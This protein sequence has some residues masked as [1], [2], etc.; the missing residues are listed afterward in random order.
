LKRTPPA[1]PALG[2]LTPLIALDVVVLDTETT[3][4]D[5]RKD[6]IVQIGAVRMVGR[7]ILANETFDVIV[8]PQMPIPEVAQRIHGLKDADVAGSRTIADV[9]PELAAFIGGA[10]VVGHSIH[11]D[12]AILRH[13]AERTGVA[14]TEPK[15]LDVALMVAGLDPA[16]VD[17]SLDNLALNLGVDI[18]GRHTALGDARATADVY[19]GLQPRLIAKGIRTLAEAEHLCRKPAGLIA[20][21]EEA[22]W[23]ERPKDKRDFAHAVLR[24]G[25][26]KAIDSYLYRNRLGDVMSSPPISL[27]QTAP[28][29]K[30]ARLMTDRGIGCLI[31][32][33]DGLD[34]GILTE[35]D[36]LHALAA[37]GSDAPELSV[38]TLM[39]APVISAPADTFLYRAL[40]LMARRNLRYLGVTDGGGRVTGV[41]TLR[42]LLRERALATLT[43][44]DEIAAATRPRDLAKVQS[45][46][47]ALASGLLDDGQ[48][49]RNVCA[50]IAAEGKAMTARAAELAEAELVAAGAGPAPADYALLVLGSG[51][52][53]ESML[54]ADQDNALVIDDSYTGDLDSPDDWFTRFAAR[55]NEILDR[56]GIPLCSGGVMARNRPWRRRLGEWEGQLAEWAAHPSP[57]ALLNVDIFYDFTP[58]QVSGSAGARLAEAL[59]IHAMETARASLTM[60]RAL[61]ETAASHGP[62]LGLFGRIRKDDQGRVD[63]K[64]GGLLPIVAGARTIALRQGISDLT[65]PGRLLAAAKAAHRSE[66]DAEILANIHGFLIRLILTQQIADLQAGIPPSNRIEINRLAH[67][68]HDEL[69]EA[70]GRIELMVHMLR[71][72][73]QGI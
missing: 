63:L 66:A 68:D 70:L 62:P 6:R 53:G 27:P 46:L 34:P 16:L 30:A 60:L 14:W 19:V 22:G 35:R 38:S 33:R 32:E 29:S 36:V 73:L 40:G 25:S 58:A 72:I 39:T 47:P 26:R 11:F 20:R 2:A 17:T 13:E 8:D 67:R 23:F 3:G 42:T 21:Q 65:T 50:I 48:D 54:A 12:L 44:G 5:I 64:A 31:I 10:V 57:Q 41:F 56:A 24:S 55:V 49:A 4:L 37:S 59:R 18:K 51:G 45:A 15:A 9:L 1:A 43:V 52:R 69:R 61:G 7:E 71:D 28:L